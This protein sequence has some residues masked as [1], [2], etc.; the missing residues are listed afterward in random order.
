MAGT[1]NEMLEVDFGAPLHSMVICS[2][3]LHE[4]EE[5]MLATFTPAKALED[6]E[7]LKSAMMAKGGRCCGSRIGRRG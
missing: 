7:R 3:E 1:I 5:Q 4:L 2:S 6:L